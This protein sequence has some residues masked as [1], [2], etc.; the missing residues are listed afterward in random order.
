MERFAKI[1]NIG[2]RRKL[3]INAICRCC[4][5]ENDEKY[6]VLGQ[7]PFSDDDGAEFREKV[8]KLTG[9][10][11]ETA[12]SSRYKFNTWL[13]FPQES[14]FSQQTKCRNRCVLCVWIK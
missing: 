11:L 4:G 5:L 12:D 2:T 7:N 14:M 6:P 13:C 8:S 1:K 10:F 3:D 9:K